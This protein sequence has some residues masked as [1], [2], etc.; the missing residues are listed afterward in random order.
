LASDFLGKHSHID[1]VTAMVSLLREL[2]L[3]CEHS[4][5][6]SL[7]IVLFFTIR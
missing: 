3:A 6:I 7:D 4:L 2:L 5:N 1:W